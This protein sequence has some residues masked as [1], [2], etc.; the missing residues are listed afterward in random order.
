MM[1]DEGKSVVGEMVVAEGVDKRYSSAQSLKWIRK[2]DKEYGV[3]CGCDQQQEWLLPW[4]WSRYQEENN[5]PVTFIDFGMTQQ[6]RRWCQDHGEVSVLHLDTSFIKSKKDICPHSAQ[7]WEG[8]YGPTLWLARKS[9][10]QKPFALLHSPYKKTLWMDL[11]CETLS[12]ITD[13]FHYCDDSQLAAVPEYASALLADVRYNGGVIVFIHGAEIIQKWAEAAILRNHCFWSD[14]A[15]LSA[16]IQ[17]QQGYIAELP[18]IYNWRISRGININAII[19]H[20]VGSAG[21][22]YIEN[23]GGIKPR[24]RAFLRKQLLT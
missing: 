18:D 11:D 14:D 6:A 15:L 8:F 7:K 3:L 23:F 4:W 16:L 5:L 22:A 19:H 9:W 10:F 13:I 12:S 21:K 2:P 17:E 24:L 1:K 20:W